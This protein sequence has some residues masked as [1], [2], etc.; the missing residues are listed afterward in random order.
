MDTA[1]GIKIDRIDAQQQYDPKAR[2]IL[3]ENPIYFAIRDDAAV[4]AAGPDALTAVKDALTAEPKAAPQFTFE[5][6]LARLADL[7][8]EENKAAPQA[9][10]EAFKGH[11]GGDK[12]RFTVDGGKSLKAHFVMGAQAIKFLSLLDAAKH[13]SA[14][15]TAPEEPAAAK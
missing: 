7:M 13:G 14:Q 5:V 9:A 11:K 2:K 8:A 6:S 1:A 4:V 3:G 12:V 10:K 15:E